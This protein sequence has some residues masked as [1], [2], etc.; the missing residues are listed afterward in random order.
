MGRSEMRQLLNSY[1]KGV[2][3]DAFHLLRPTKLETQLVGEELLRKRAEAIKKAR[4]FNRRFVEAMV[5]DLPDLCAGPFSVEEPARPVCEVR[6]LEP[7]VSTLPASS[8]GS[9]A[10]VFL[11]LFR[12]WSLACD[13]V[14]DSTYRPAAEELRKLLPD[15]GDVLVP[16]CGLGRLALA[17]AAQGYKVEA[18]DASRLFLTA[19]DYL[20]NRPPAAMKIF[21]L[22]H[23]F[24]ENWSLDQQ[25]IEIEVPGPAPSSIIGSGAS[26]ALTMVPGDFAKTYGRGGPGHRKFAAIV[27]CFFIDTATDLVELFDVLDGLL[28]EG[29]I[30]LNV[31]PLNWKKDARLKLAYEEIVVIWQNMG[32]E[33]VSQKRIDCDYHMPRGMKMYTESYQGALTAAIKRRPSPAPS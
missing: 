4:D 21:P 8:Y 20:L 16:G 31:G 13:H 10:S 26:P 25:Y 17:L 7:G 11:H 12:D 3:D 2:E 30:W 5:E 19:A 15:G 24:S 18:N 33:F 32:Y 23:V 14:N 6:E 27:T 29:G 9:M 22:A 1:E 28:D